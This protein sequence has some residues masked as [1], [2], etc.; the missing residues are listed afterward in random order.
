[1]ETQHKMQQ[2]NQAYP[3]HESLR[4]TNFTAFADA[5]FEFSPAINVLVGENGTGKTHLMKALYVAQYT[6]TRFVEVGVQLVFR[7][8]FQCD[9]VQS[10]FRSSRGPAEFVLSGR[11]GGNDWSLGVDRDH[12]GDVV[13]KV[14]GI[15]LLPNVTVPVFIPAVDMIGH[16]RRFVST[17][18]VYQIDFDQTHRDIVALLLS[19]ERREPP[20]NLSVG[21]SLE[22]LLGGR[23]VEDKERFYLE[24]RRSPIPMPLVAEGVRKVATLYQLVRNGLLDP[25]SVLFWDEPEVNVNPKLMDEI[26]D[27]LLRLA[28]S[29]VQIFLAT[30]SYEILKEL[31][32]Q[33]TADDNVRYFALERTDD[34]TVVHAT[35]DYAQLDP[36]LIAE[37]YDSIYD[38]ELGKALGR[39]RRRG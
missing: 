23:L 14:D 29:G 39:E 4:L 34:G 17:Y 38:R 2:L 18:D 31:D 32:L 30:H 24:T 8:V 3:H 12:L 37:Q 1:M 13:G 25:G 22:A 21:K 36:N 6:A 20:Q 33:A 5:S 35:D 16:T 10:L 7:G 11:W 28:R 9:T 15:P 27:V 19:P 26:V